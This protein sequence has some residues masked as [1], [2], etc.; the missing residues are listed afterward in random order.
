M[1]YCFSFLF[2]VF[3]FFLGESCI[4]T[5]NLEN[6]GY[7][8]NSH[9]PFEATYNTFTMPLSERWASQP[10]SR[11]TVAL[12][13]ASGLAYSQKNPGKLWSHQDSGN[14]NMLF[15]ID[16][17][18]GEIITRYRIEGTVNI[19]WEDIEIS[20]GPEEG[21]TYLYVSDTGD[22]N[23]RR[24]SYTIYRFIE[25]AFDESHT[26]QTITLSNLQIDQINFEYPDGSHDT[27]G[28]LVDPMTLDIFLATKRDLFST[29]YV[30]PYPQDTKAL[31]Q[32]FKAGE[33]GFRA[34]S[35]ATSNLAGDQ[36]LIKNRQEIFFWERNE[37][38]TMVEM[39]GRTPIRAPYIGEPQGEAICFDP[40][41]GYFTLSE[42]SNSIIPVLYYY[43]KII[44]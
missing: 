30:L 31:D 8:W 2:I 10:Q 26:G 3:T 43:E 37:S 15:L 28:L 6:N 27:E 29:L 19:D 42:F 44:P 21:E 1:K 23:Q 5:D 22:N 9:K 7:N 40:D 14:T 12:E 13:E 20:F 24:R 32:A 36:V 4:S 17:E 16:A 41:G 18:T 39:F 34:T 11:G 33:F 38:E 25:P 35:A